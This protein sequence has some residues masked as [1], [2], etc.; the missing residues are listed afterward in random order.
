MNIRFHR[1]I[2]IKEYSQGERFPAND[3][4]LKNIWDYQLINVFYITLKFLLGKY[5]LRA[6]NSSQ[7]S[8]GPVD[9]QILEDSFLGE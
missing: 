9:P 3:Y 7:V 5:N 4:V 1:H 8:K 2:L 6:T